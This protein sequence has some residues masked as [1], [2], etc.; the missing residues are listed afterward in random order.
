MILII[1]KIKITHSNHKT[2]GQIYQLKKNNMLNIELL[3]LIKK[4]GGRYKANSLDEANKFCREIAESH[5]ENFPVASKLMPEK[6]RQDVFNIYA[7]A[8]IADDIGDEL[9]VSPEEKI[10]ALNKYEELLF[11]AEL[12]SATQGN[13]VFIALNN[14]VKAKS[15][16]KE[17]LQRLL[18]AFK[19]DSDFVQPNTYEDIEN[20]CHYSANPIG[21]LVLRVF[22]LWN[23]VTEPLSNAVC[24][25]L[26]VANFWQDLSRDIPNGRIYIPKSVLEEYSIENINTCDK[27]TLNDLM[28]ELCNYSES[29]LLQGLKL[30]RKLKPFKLKLE[31][32]A[33]I[34]GGLKIVNETRRLQSRIFTERPELSKLNFAIILIKAFF[35]L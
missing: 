26:Q 32:A 31:I 14:T 2:F 19:M 8:R 3:E 17:T 30:P 22:R 16:P 13:P 33:T 18:T 15:L 25:G 21:E 34:E 24:T 4:D 11:D 6:E 35:L 1:H 28:F 9:K 27:E 10:K 5:Y 29:L 7:F 20:Y 23:K 12:I